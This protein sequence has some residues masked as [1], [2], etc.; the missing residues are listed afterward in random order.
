MVADRNVTDGEI[1]RLKESVKCLELDL[2]KE[3]LLNERLV[4][5]SHDE[6]SGDRLA[7]SSSYRN[8]VCMKCVDYR[9]DLVFEAKRA[10]EASEQAA[11]AM[12]KLE[13]ERNLRLKEMEKNENNAY[14]KVHI[15]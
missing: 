2:Q 12:S 11:L 8:F 5:R 10:H 9:R 4:Q 7:Q 13:E 3:R 14:E 1:D 6:S 15:I